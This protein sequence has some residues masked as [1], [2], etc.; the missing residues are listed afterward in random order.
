MKSGVE[1]KAAE[2]SKVEAHILRG[3]R[4]LVVGAKQ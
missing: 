4:T 1:L 2:K 3:L